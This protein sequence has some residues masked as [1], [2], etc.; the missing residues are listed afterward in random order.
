[1]I[2]QSLNKPKQI[3]VEIIGDKAIVSITENVKSYKNE[4]GKT[5]YEYDL[6]QFPNVRYHDNLE[7]NVAN[8]IGQWLSKARAEPIKEI[9]IDDRLKALETE[10]QLQK[11]KVEYIESVDAVK[12]SLAKQAIDVT[13]KEI[14][15]K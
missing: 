4:D 2:T 9:T 6:Y 7:K 12:L 13:E 15:K 1:M 5:V 8:N 10:L 14:S 11:Q 3:T